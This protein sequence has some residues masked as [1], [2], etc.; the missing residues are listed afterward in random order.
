MQFMPEYEKNYML[1]NEVERHIQICG[2]E[3]ISFGY[4]LL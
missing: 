2:T 3:I 4:T 1:G